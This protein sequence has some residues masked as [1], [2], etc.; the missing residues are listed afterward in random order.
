MTSGAYV[1]SRP[2]TVLR[3]SLFWDVTLRRFLVGCRHFG[4]ILAVPSSGDCLTPICP[5]TSLCNIPE[6]GRPRTVLYP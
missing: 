2:H 3:D 6:K 4:D 1:L 5:E